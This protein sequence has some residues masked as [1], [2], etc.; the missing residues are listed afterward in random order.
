MPATRTRSSSS[1]HSPT[2]NLL[3]RPE[4]IVLSSDGE[5]ARPNEIGSSRTKKNTIKKP[6]F[7]TREVLEISSSDEKPVLPKA[8]GNDGSFWQRENSRLKQINEHLER[9]V[10]RQRGQLDN[11]RKCLEEQRQE[12]VAQSREIDAGHQEIK[13][14]QEKLAALQAKGKSKSI[15]AT[16][17]GDMLSCDIC[18]HLMHSPYLLSDCGHCYCE[19]CLR[20][21]F[22]ET[23]TKHIRAHPTYDVNRKLVPP[24]VPQIL[25]SIG[26]P[27]PYPIQMQL[28]AACNASRQQQPEYTCPG[29]RQ[30]IA[31]KPVVNFVVRDMVSLVGR[32]LGQPDTRKESSGQRAGPFDAFFPE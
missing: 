29:C 23:L 7:P 9:K 15:D 10:A 26:P 2:R 16:E 25:Q 18:A 14:Q 12:L 5:D 19:G 13:L 17:L 24:N 11:S 32:A 28:Q 3:G 8:P 31:K 20:G 22:D 27:L 6:T 1:R 30:E 4:V 21:W